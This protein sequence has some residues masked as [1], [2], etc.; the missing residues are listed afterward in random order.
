VTMDES[1]SIVTLRDAQ[2]GDA[3]LMHGAAGTVAGPRGS[4][5]IESREQISECHIS[6]LRVF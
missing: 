1:A 5:R 2:A 6:P 3:V 4:H